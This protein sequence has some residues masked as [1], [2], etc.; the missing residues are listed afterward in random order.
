MTSLPGERHADRSSKS[1]AWKGRVR[2]AL[3]WIDRFYRSRQIFRANRAS[4]PSNFE[5]WIERVGTA[6]HQRVYARLDALCRAFAHPT[7][8]GHH[9]NVPAGKWLHSFRSM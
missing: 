2:L 7:I 1:A 9:R 5:E 8:A 3:P 6:R 4:I